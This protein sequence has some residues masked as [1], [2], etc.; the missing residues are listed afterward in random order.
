MS[1]KNVLKD[2]ATLS[3]KEVEDSVSSGLTWLVVISAI[4]LALGAVF[5]WGWEADPLGSVALVQNFVKLHTAA[6]VFSVVKFIVSVGSAV[7]VYQLF[8]NTELAGRVNKS[9]ALA[10]L[11]I[12]A[13]LVFGVR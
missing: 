2:P 9:Y 6:L 11:L 1:A 8:E 12:A 5:G 10:A 3:K 7:G 4:L 13:A